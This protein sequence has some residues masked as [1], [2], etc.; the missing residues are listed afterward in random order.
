MLKILVLSL[1]FLSACS[2]SPKKI[3]HQ[4]KIKKRQ[5]VMLD[6]SA[7]GKPIEI[8][9]IEEIFQLTTQQRRAFLKEYH[10]LGLQSF[11]PN[12]RIYKYLEKNL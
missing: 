12:R 3:T 10:S 2:I 1:I 8:I 6:E 4:E 9:D 7:F 5:L 11:E